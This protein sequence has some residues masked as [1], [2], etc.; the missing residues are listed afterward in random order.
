MPDSSPPSYWLATG[1]RLDTPATLPKRAQVVVLGGGVFGVS[2]AL[3]LART[4]ANVL[5]L[6]QR[7]LSGG[8]TGRNAGIVAP[9]TTQSY[10]TLGETAGWDTARQV[11]Q[12]TEDSAALLKRVLAEEGV[13]AEQRVE[14]AH[15]VAMTPAE[16]ETQQ[17]TIERLAA[18][19]FE[20]AWLDRDALQAHVGL[21]LPPAF[22]G[23]RFHPRGMILHSARLVVGLAQAAQRYGAELRQGVR[24]LSIGAG[25]VETDQGTVRADHIVLATNAY[26]G[27]LIP[28]LASVIIP[29][30]GQMRSTVPLPQRVF[31]GSWSANE[32]GEYWQ[33]TLDGSWTLGGMRRRAA[34]AEVGYLTD[35]LNGVV[36]A[37]LDAF[38]G[39]HFPDLA[40]APVSHRWAGSMGFTPDQRPLI[41]PLRPGLWIAA[42]CSG[43]GMPFATEAGRQIAGWIR[44]GQPDRDMTP[45]DPHRF[46]QG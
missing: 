38:A 22:L 28:A 3:F 18:D 44:H 33:Q 34:D 4:G 20:L 21:P 13:Q 42:G 12:F 30:R 35:D 10:L 9:G 7:R 46:L 39:Q 32:G 19:G 29:T 41:G 15:T 2:A 23:A 14:G 45:F 5:V 36:Q 31:R 25:K 37:A 16:V 24:V 40:A 8:A 26:T 17:R 1:P 27:R 43:H 6:E 11:W